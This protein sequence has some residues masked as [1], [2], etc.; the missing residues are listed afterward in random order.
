MTERPD[1]AVATA[2]ARLGVDRLL[3]GIHDP[4]FPRDPDEDLGR[5]SPATRAGRRLLDFARRLGFTGVQLGPQGLVSA[6][7]ASPYD[8]AHFSRDTLSIPLGTLLGEG[9]APPLVGA[10]SV[11]REIASRPDGPADR[12]SHRHAFAAMERLLDEAFQRFASGRG[13]PAASFERWRAEQGEWLSRDALFAWLERV[14]L[15]SDWR[16]WR[17]TPESELDRVLVA[18]PPHLAAD[19]ARRRGLVEAIHGA[20]LARYGFGQWLAHRSHH[21]VRA[22][23]AALGLELYGDLQVGYSRRDEWAAQA[24]LLD[25]YRLGAPPSRTTPRGQPWNYPVLHPASLTASPEGA[26]MRWLVARFR[27][28]LGEFDGLRIDHPHGYVCPWVYR[29]ADADAHHAVQHGARLFESP[30]LADHP[31]LARFAR[32]SGA[33]LDPAPGAPRFADDWVVRLAPEQVERYAATVDRWIAEARRAGRAPAAVV[34]EVLSTL[35]YPLARVIVRHGLGRFRVLQKADPRDPTDVYHVEAARPEDWVMLGNH[36]TPPIWAVMEGWSAA[37]RRDP[38]VGVLAARLAPEGS[39]RTRVAEWLAVD[40]GRL[41]HALLAAMLACPARQ[42]M[43]FWTDLF[44]VRE[45]YNTPGTISDLNWS[46]CLTPDFERVHAER[47]AR[48]R[49]LDLRFALG[50]AL[51]M[52]A[53]AGSSLDPALAAALLGSARV[54][55]PAPPL[56]ADSGAGR[57]AARDRAS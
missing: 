40:P 50:L 14:N 19:A 41:A 44:G 56:R 5:G 6:G 47:I 18:P 9:E 3:L 32:V 57:R 46:L 33:D 38:W 22:Y 35:P 29:A 13:G 36:D 28:L 30:D 53:A 51:H 1:A 21:D 8:G 27:K 20:A 37:E 15:G 25:G 17:G 43:L 31:E 7:N 12:T 49:A 34:C 55:W 42:A 24:W 23:A 39:E 45:P 54:P 2:L 26:G 16:S 10:E 52:E 4:S 11:A 48:G